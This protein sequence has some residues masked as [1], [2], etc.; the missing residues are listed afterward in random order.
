MDRLKE[1][2][3]NKA[4]EITQLGSEAEKKEAKIE[5]QRVEIETNKQKQEVRFLPYCTQRK[6]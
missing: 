4:G 6:R 1:E 2:V 3:K 5:E